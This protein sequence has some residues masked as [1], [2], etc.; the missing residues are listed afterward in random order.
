MVG[1]SFQGCVIF[2]SSEMM[3]TIAFIAFV[4]AYKGLIY[5]SVSLPERPAAVLRPS[6][7]AGIPEQ[8]DARIFRSPT[9]SL[10]R[11]DIT[12]EKNLG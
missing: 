6:H 8:G 2:F 12:P 4:V 10:Y 3:I 7:Y 9:S 5:V 1:R 11:P